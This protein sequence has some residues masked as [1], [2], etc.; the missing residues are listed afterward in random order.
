MFK[1]NRKIVIIASSIVLIFVIVFSTTFVIYQYRINT[2]GILT[3][4]E[5]IIILNDKDFKNYKFP[6]RGT[7]NNPYLIQYYNI[8]ADHSE[9]IYISGTTKHFIIQNCYLNSYYTNI[10]IENSK[11]SV[12][13][14]E[15]NIEG[16]LQGINIL[17]SPG[18]NIKGNNI[19]VVSGEAIFSFNTELIDCE[20]S[21]ITLNTF[22]NGTFNIIDSGGVTIDKN[23]FYLRE[24]GYSGDNVFDIDSHNAIISENIFDSEG[25]LVIEGHNAI[26]SENSFVSEEILLVLGTNVII[27]GNFFETDGYIPIFD[28]DATVSDNLFE[29]DGYIEILGD[30]ATVSDNLFESGGYIYASWPGNAKITGNVFEDGGL[31]DV[32]TSNSIISNNQITNGGY[33]IYDASSTVE[34]NLVNGKELGYFLNLEDQIFS[35]NTYGQFIFLECRNLTIRDLDIM[36]TSH[37]IFIASSS[38][39][40]ITNNNLQYDYEGI[41][42]IESYNLNISE[43]FL[44]HSGIVLSR[45]DGSFAI[46]SSITNNIGYNST[47]YVHGSFVT[48]ENNTLTDTENRETEIWESKLRYIFPGSLYGIGL[49]SGS[50]NII[51]NNLIENCDSGIVWDTPW[52]SI[53]Y[54]NTCNFVETGISIYN[55]F[56]MYNVTIDNNSINAT[57]TS[58]KLGTCDTFTISNNVMSTGINFARGFENYETF[59]IV[60]NTIDGRLLGFYADAQNLNLSSPEFGSLYLIN[61]SNS[62]ISNQVIENSATEIMLESCNNVSI[63]NSSFTNSSGLTIAGSSNCIVKNNTLR[64]SEMYLEGT[65]N[66]TI[67]ENSCYDSHNVLLVRHSVD[68]IITNNTFANGDYGIYVAYSF[69]CTINYN[70]ITLNHILGIS[71]FAQITENITIHHNAFIDNQLL[72]DSQAEDYGVNNVFY[73]INTSEGNYWSNWISGSYSIAGSAGSYDPY[74][75]SSNPL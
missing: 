53:L 41:V 22:T 30:D 45:G 70:L 42:A 66:C 44:N 18:T 67:I 4:H 61:C 72:E 1:L 50:N 73:D 38:N 20:N 3:D 17:N 46:N 68:C 25:L 33:A 15:N 39:I 24:T 74:P 35:D 75:L 71:L 60:N 32:K 19:T 21:I 23:E 54:N 12:Q 48:I 6:G 7:E 37:G 31:I 13:I 47:I 63:T 14:I 43:N 51:Q 52:N 28:D 9:S 49:H 56:R 10:F 27:S 57:K 65:S 34:N 58:I 5:P 11:G 59:T 16:A 55:Y 2:H 64:N 69:N 29:T 40:S 8:T 36:N 62:V 26:V